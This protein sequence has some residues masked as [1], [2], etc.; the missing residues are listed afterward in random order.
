[1]FVAV[2]VIQ[3]EVMI[4]AKIQMNKDNVSISMVTEPTIF[5]CIDW[6]SLVN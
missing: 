3:G 2:D 4:V 6:T 1:M 5:L